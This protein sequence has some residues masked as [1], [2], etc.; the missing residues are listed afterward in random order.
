MVIIPFLVESFYWLVEWFIASPLLVCSCRIVT[1]LIIGCTVVI[2]AALLLS[3][4]VEASIVAWLNGLL[5][6][7]REDRP[8][9]LTLEY[10]AEQSLVLVKVIELAGLL[11][12]LEQQLLA[13]FG[14][15][16]RVG[17]NILEK[18][19]KERVDS[20]NLLV[21]TLV[22]QLEYA[23]DSL[24]GGILSCHR[25]LPFLRCQGLFIKLN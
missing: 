19:N 13:L 16:L 20:A 22:G 11:V 6:C 10:L 14:I 9:G 15:L 7:S 5:W 1:W 2:A 23:L 17:L 18:G 25:G 8:A 12:G 21:F 4:L 3:G 24:L